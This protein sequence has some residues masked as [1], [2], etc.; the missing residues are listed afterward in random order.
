MG[1]PVNPFN[2]FNNNIATEDYHAVILGG[3]Q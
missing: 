3:R 1:R 2:Y